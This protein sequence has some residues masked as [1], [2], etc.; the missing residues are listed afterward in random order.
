MN[1]MDIYSHD[2]ILWKI[3]G[4]YIPKTLG[5]L[6]ILNYRSLMKAIQNEM[7]AE[8]SMLG[9]IRLVQMTFLPMFSNLFQEPSIPLSTLTQ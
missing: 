3:K 1:F 2:L 6:H 9:R 7:G 8:K 4:T 5:K